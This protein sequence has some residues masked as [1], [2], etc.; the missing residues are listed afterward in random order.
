[1]IVEQF[2]EHRAVRVVERRFD[3]RGG[4]AGQTVEVF[5]CAG[6]TGEGMPA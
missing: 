6:S 5:E 3:D 1:V 2:A 4:I